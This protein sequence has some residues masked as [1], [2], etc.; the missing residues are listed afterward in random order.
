[1][2]WRPLLALMAGLTVLAGCYDTASKLPPSELPNPASAY[3]KRVGGKPE[4]RSDAKG[5]QA[6]V[7]HLRGGAV[8]DE[9]ALFRG[10]IKGYPG[11][12]LKDG[13]GRSARR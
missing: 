11:P 2:T 6:G 4:I 9:W 8:V 5:A 13:P 3:C 1:M 7:C 12:H 10:E